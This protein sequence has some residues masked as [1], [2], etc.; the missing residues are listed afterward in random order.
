MDM[1]ELVCAVHKK[2]L[3]EFLDLMVALGETRV[4][5]LDDE[6]KRQAQLDLVESL[7]AASEAAKRLRD[8]S[9]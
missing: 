3:V 9:R 4:Y 8:A 5:D 7:T 2:G 1:Y 6:V